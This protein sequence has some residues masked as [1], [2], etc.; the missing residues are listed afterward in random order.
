MV[1][2]LGN[3]KASFFKFSD[4]V[5]LENIYSIY[6]ISSFFPTRN[7]FTALFIQLLGLIPGFTIYH[8]TFI[9][10]ENDTHS[11]PRTGV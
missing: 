8:E 9:S 6:I 3:F 7:L 5:V 11:I 4:L 2:I 10:T 1:F